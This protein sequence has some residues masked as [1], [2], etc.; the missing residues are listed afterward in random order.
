MMRAEAAA[1]LARLHSDDRNATD[2][3]GFR[4][5]LGVDH[6]HR[7][8]FDQVSAAWEAAGGD[9]AD[10]DTAPVRRRTGVRTAVFAIAASLVVGMASLYAILPRPQYFST[11]LGEQKRVVL[12]DGSTML[13]DTSS[14]AEVSFRARERLVKLVRG[15]VHFEIVHDP[16]RPFVVAFGK[17]QVTDIGTT[18]DVLMRGDVSSVVLS[19]G[20][21]VVDDGPVHRK[22]DPGER[23]TFLRGRTVMDKPDLEILTAWQ[24]GRLV[25]QKRSLQDV[26]NELNRYSQ[27]QLFIADPAIASLELSGTYRLGDTAGF[28]TSVSAL[29]PVAADLTSDKIIL[30]ARDIPEPESSEH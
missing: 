5:W 1:W 29:L 17:R 18:F 30:S 7:E 12:A 23:L 19:S 28:A 16:A 26:V 20:E 6:L 14:M 3:A 21:V 8:A 10:F 13:L 4:A 2:D 25:F 15:Q 22:L 24:S 9:F 11:G 27:R